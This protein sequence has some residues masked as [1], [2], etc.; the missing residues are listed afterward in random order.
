MKEKTT[1]IGK[2]KIKWWNDKEKTKNPILEG[3][4]KAAMTKE[5]IASI[6][7]DGETQSFP[8]EE[9]TLSEAQ[10]DG[11]FIKTAMEILKDKKEQGLGLE[12]IKRVKRLEQNKFKKAIK[13][14]IDNLRFNASE[15]RKIIEVEKAIHILK[16]EL[17]EKL[18]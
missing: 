4:I 10:M 2:A 6:A 7:L 8:L 18:S 1:K 15:K 13:R 3:A 17:G 14:Y 11:I 12:L 9:K 16:N 5:A